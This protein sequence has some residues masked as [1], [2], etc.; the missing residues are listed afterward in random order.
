MTR[1]W[2]EEHLSEIPAVQ[3]L[4]RLGWSY[5]AAEE[6][7]AERESQKEVV[8]GGRLKKEIKKLNPWISD[9]N[10]NRAMRAVTG[11]Q[12]ASLLEANEKLYTTLTYGVSLEQDLGDGVKGRT[13]RFFDF[14][15]PEHNEFLITRQLEVRGA[16]QRIIPDI[17]C[18][19]NGI[20]IAVIEC[21]SPALGE[22]WK[23]EAVE[24]FHRYQEIGEEYRGLGAPRLFETVQI[25]VA[26]CGQA[27]A[28]GTVA[29][30][31]RFFSEWKH[32]Y[33]RTIAD[34]EADLGRK[35]TPQDILLYG[36]LDPENL[37]D[38]VRNFITFERGQ[39][40]TE[41]K[42]CRYQQF[43]AVNK[44]L[45]RARKARKGAG[46]GGVVWHT[47]GSGKSLSMLWL[48]LKLRRAKEFDN[49]TLVLV[50]DRRDLD[51]QISNTFE[52]CGFP[53]PERADSVRDLRDRL[54]GTA[55]RTVLTT[56]QKFQELM[57]AGEN[58]KLDKKL[59]NHPVLSEAHNIFVLVDEAHRTQYRSL[60]ANMRRALPNACFFGFTGTPIDKQDRSTLTTFGPY[61]DTYTIEQ[62]VADGATVP[63]FY[64][65]RLPELRVIGA[66]L[67]QLFDRVFADRSV[68]EREAIKDRYASEAAIA[69][70]PKRIEAIGL[71]LIEHY[72]KFI[73]PNGFKAQVVACTRDAAVSYKET[74]DRLHAPES[75]ILMSGSNDDPD[76]LKRHHTTDEQ[77][78]DVIQRFLK[79]NDPL[80]ILVVCDMLITGFDAPVEQVMYL[81]SPLREHNLLQAI[82]R[83]NRPLDSKDYGLIV[84]YWGI[85]EALQEA[86]AIFAPTDIHGA[87]TPKGDELPRL[88]TRHAVAIRYL[89]KVRS[90]NDLDACVA[91]LEAEDV[92]AEFD[93]AF[94]RFA[95]SMDMLLPDPKALKYADDLRWLGKIRQAVRARY[96]DGRV[97]ISDCGAKARKLIEEAIIADGVQILV[98]KVNLFSKELD[99]KLKA[100]KSDEAR[101]SEMEHAIRHEIHVR[102]EENPVFFISL[103]ERLEKIIQDLKAKRLSAAEA[104][105][106][107]L[108]LREDLQRPERAAEKLGLTPTGHAIYGL[109]RR[110]G[111]T[112]G[113]GEPAE[114]WDGEV[115]DDVSRD[116]AAAVE[117][118]LN[119]FVDM[120]DWDQ[121][122]DVQREMRKT[123]KRRLGDR[124]PREQKDRAA[125]EIIDL[126]KVRR[127]R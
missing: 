126:L 32:P 77:R 127:G 92:R 73:Q 124:Y 53:N 30:E 89:A 98:Q 11:I 61:I 18:Y 86:L 70:A 27:A 118:E 80:L 121:K 93:E 38:L 74:L 51:T 23:H 105:Q 76:R 12:T 78:R 106:L 5:V 91:A 84:D 117:Q 3:V 96:R 115:L 111:K 52:H 108:P 122:D 34:V 50:T 9:D 113:V 35:A 59:G 54:T 75:A 116:L 43:A 100:L 1:D 41:K 2:N 37:L 47:Q 112:D 19:V 109:L 97:D 48:C 85:S 55:G 46:R 21:K 14:E 68:E 64:E 114:I 56:I 63:I 87:L 107:M 62:A 94:R 26:S 60:A 67:D 24:Q 119:P 39:N 10:A 28:C 16:R 125:A 90:R 4:E 45:D 82:A 110:A 66:T 102:L 88:Q 57:P 22:K 58:G 81:D 17:V 6:L 120:V 71:D 65:S 99:E 31:H 36:V 69:G 83:T 79:K 8:L 104:L 7:E 33:P 44:A 29:T 20:P 25:L 40:R 95:Q 103:K 123:I 101:A 49:P 15:K 42:L 72:T 13:V